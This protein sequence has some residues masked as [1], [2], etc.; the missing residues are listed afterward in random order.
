MNYKAKRDSEQSPQN[1]IPPGQWGRKDKKRLGAGSGH[2]AIQQKAFK[3]PN[4]KN[5]PDPAMAD[6]GPCIFALSLGRGSVPPTKR[7]TTQAQSFYMRL[8]WEKQNLDDKLTNQVI[9][10]K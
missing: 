2:H 4:T 6:D 7:Y 1:G 3:K 10:P 5:S 8:S 9:L